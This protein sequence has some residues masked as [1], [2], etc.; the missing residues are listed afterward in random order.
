MDSVYIGDGYAALSRG[1]ALIDPSGGM[2]MA[3]MVM[4]YI[5]AKGSVAPKLEGR[6]S[7]K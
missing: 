4:D 7:S 3:T 2:L 6:I 5:A 1:K